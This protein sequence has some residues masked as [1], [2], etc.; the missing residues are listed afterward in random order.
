M[1]GINNKLILVITI[2]LTLLVVGCSN[3]SQTDGNVVADTE[4]FVNVE[5]LEIY[6]FHGTNQCYSCITVGAYAEETVNNYFADEIKS[7]KI[8]FGHINGELLENKDLVMKYESTG[9]SLWLGT[10]SE[11]GKFSAEQNVKVWYKINDKQDYMNYLKGVIEQKL[12]G[13]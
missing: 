13:K 10:Y 4:H 1:V 5:K 11:D 8:I 9:S 12:A 7:G 2:V 6:H 3:N